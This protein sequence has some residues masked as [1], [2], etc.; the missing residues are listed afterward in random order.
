MKAALGKV[1]KT[2]EEL[3]KGVAER[4]EDVEKQLK[5]VHTEARNN[6]KKAEESFLSELRKS[7]ERLKLN[8][9]KELETEVKNLENRIVKSVSSDVSRN[10]NVQ[11][12]AMNDELKSDVAKE[13]KGL[14]DKLQE[15]KQELEMKIMSCTVPG[16]MTANGNAMNNG[17]ENNNLNSSSDVTTLVQNIVNEKLKEDEEKKARSN[18]LVIFGLLEIEGIDSKERSDCDLNRVVDLLTY[19]GTKLGKEDVIAVTRIGKKNNAGASVRPLLV[20]VKDERTKWFIISKGNML[21]QS[22][23]WEGIYMAPDLTQNERKQE[24]KLKEDLKKRRDESSLNRDGRQWTIKKG[25][26]VEKQSTT[27]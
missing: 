19:A 15:M 20:K 23:D 4:F 14:E 8:L 25:Q 6:V 24:K 3:E 10:L 11:K 9:H 17:S 27:H 22:K 13:G 26:I 5:E 21:K 16:D 2:L 7:D 12:K 18:G 1:I